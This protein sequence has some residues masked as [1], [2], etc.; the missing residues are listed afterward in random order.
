[1]KEFLNQIF[2]KTSQTIERNLFDY[3]LANP[4]VINSLLFNDIY[5][6]KSNITTCL[7]HKEIFSEFKR[8]KKRPILY[9][10]SIDDKN[11]DANTLR[12]KYLEFKDLKST[13]NSAAYKPFLDI[14][15]K[16]LYVGK[17]KKDFHL[18]LVTHLGY[19][20]NKDTAGMQLFHWYD[21][22]ELGNL[23]LNYIIFKEEMS[24]LITILEMEFARELKPII[25]RY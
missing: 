17:V 24:D 19:S 3:E 22:E 11:I 5:C 18:R 10:F 23:I 16:T 13:R 9:W 25:G 21:P 7:E 2:N 4:V 12:D 8:I 20:R 6:E 14:Y 1:M 15:S